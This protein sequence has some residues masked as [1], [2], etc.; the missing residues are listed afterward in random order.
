MAPCILGG[1]GLVRSI[2]PIDVLGLPLGADWWVA[3]VTPELRIETRE[4]R[5]L[6]PDEWSRAD[7]VQQMA[8]TAGL[9][10]AFLA[11]DAEL[12]R[13]SLVDRFAEPRRAHLI[14]RFYEVQAAARGAGALGC[15]ISGSGPTLFA[16]TEGES[17]ALACEEAMRRAF[18]EVPALSHVCRI[19]RQGAR[20]V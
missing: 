4:A 20:R 3:L 8:N 17:A 7:W 18:E 6:L 15:S 11:G 14:P 2:D 12:A 19:G 9:V 1:L 10:A 5:R 13:R 16:L